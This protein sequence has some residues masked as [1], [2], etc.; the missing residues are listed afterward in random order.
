M[1]FSFLGSPGFNS[2]YSP[3]LHK[4]MALPLGEESLPSTCVR[5]LPS[6]E[7]PRGSSVDFAP[8]SS[9]MG[10]NRALF[11]YTSSPCCNP[12]PKMCYLFPFQ[13]ISSHV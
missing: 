10:Q 13:I 12:R 6:F 7:G 11:K 1:G 3:G 4:C 5:P 2:V 9:G 8:E